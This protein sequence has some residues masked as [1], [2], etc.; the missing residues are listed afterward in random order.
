MRRFTL[1]YNDSMRGARLSAT[2]EN[3]LDDTDTSKS[4]RERL[5]APHPR[6]RFPARLLR[7]R[8]VI[9]VTDPTTRRCRNPFPNTRRCL[10]T[11]IDFT[12]RLPIPGRHIFIREDQLPS[13]VSNGGAGR[14]V[15][16]REG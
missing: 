10:A 2:R 1:G 8:R 4:K 9:K 14:S 13:R 11:S 16:R 12:A 6:Q 15:T 5:R 7:H 3:V